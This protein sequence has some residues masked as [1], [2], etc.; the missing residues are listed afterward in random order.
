MIGDRGTG[1]LTYEGGGG[2]VPCRIVEWTARA[3]ELED[4]VGRG[5]DSTMVWVCGFV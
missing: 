5:D 2:V 3:V 4:G 1:L